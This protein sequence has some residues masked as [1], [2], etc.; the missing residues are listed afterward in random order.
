MSHRGLLIMGPS[1]VCGPAGAAPTLAAEADVALLVPTPNQ[2][3]TLVVGGKV[4]IAD[5]SREGMTDSDITLPRFPGRLRGHVG[6]EPR[7]MEQKVVRP[8]RPRWASSVP[9]A[10]ACRARHPAR[11]RV[12]TEMQTLQR[13]KGSCRRSTRQQAD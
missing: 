11:A 7:E 10:T 6:P 4:Q 5:V 12:P 8:A 3:L 9:L 13:P 2:P 1:I